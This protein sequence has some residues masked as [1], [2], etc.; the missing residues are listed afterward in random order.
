M[1]RILCILV[2]VI[3]L[4]PCVTA[5][6]ESYLALTFDDGPSG[7]FTADLLDGL[8]ERG[9]QATFFLCG[10]R[11]EQFP[12][13]TARIAA[14]GHEIGAHGDTHSYFSDLSP[15]E[16]CR[17]LN[18]SM[19]KIRRATGQSPTLLRP[20]GG[21]FD[22]KRLEQTDCAHLPVILWSVDPED[23]CCSS[24]ETIAER[25][26]QKA[27]SGDIILLH[28]MSDSS[29]QAAFKLIDRLQER[30]FRFVT[31]SELARLSGT[32]L[33]GGRSY[34]SFSFAKNASISLREAAT[35]PC[36]KPGLP[37]P[38]PCNSAFRRRDSSRTS[39]SLHPI[40]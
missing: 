34:Y 28:D 9:V 4:C 14:E 2:C 24:S 25:V 15:A 39:P 3:F 40:A 37:P 8:Q 13:L 17:D 1:I 7:H 16:L 29:V 5:K 30:G 33:S 21:L 31:V 36:T 23:W 20:P 11:V 22:L 38:L 35:E 6:E 18:A 26:L 12:A 27:G 19:E 32:K 10:Y